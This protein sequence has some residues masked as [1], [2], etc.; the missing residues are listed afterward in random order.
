MS[1]RQATLG[2]ACTAPRDSSR[3]TARQLYFWPSFLKR[4]AEIP[5]GY[6]AEFSHT[7]REVLMEICKPLF[8]S[9]TTLLAAIP[10]C[11]NDRGAVLD[12]NASPDWPEAMMPLSNRVRSGLCCKSSIVGRLRPK[13]PDPYC[14]DPTK[15]SS[16]SKTSRAASR[17]I[18]KL[19]FRNGLRF[20][21]S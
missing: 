5:E 11:G 18:V 21:P 14:K 10:S 6:S 3:K 16:S 1:S 12:S 17:G 4:D 20:W 19:P 7:S 15:P 13:L 9:P 8:G 2:L